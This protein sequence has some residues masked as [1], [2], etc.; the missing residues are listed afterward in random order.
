L[1]DPKLCP[2]CGE[3]IQDVHATCQWA[4]KPN[5]KYKTYEMEVEAF[6]KWYVLVYRIRKQVDLTW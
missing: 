6:S 5:G 4:W 3:V 1:T 2:I